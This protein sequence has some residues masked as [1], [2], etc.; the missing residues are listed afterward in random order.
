MESF[1]QTQKRNEP[2]DNER[3][4]KKRRSNGNYARVAFLREKDERMEKIQK[5]ELELKRLLLEKEECF[6]K[7]MMT[8]QQQQQKQLQEFQAMMNMQAK[9]QSDLVLALV[10][11]LVDKH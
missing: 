3:R 1:G 10:L 6:M 4:K 8:Q 9:Q 2:E 7:V 11:K 5:E